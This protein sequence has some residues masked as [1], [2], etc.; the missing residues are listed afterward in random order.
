MSS[1]PE[2]VLRTRR[3]AYNGRIIV[4]EPGEQPRPEELLDLSLGGGFVKSL[5]PPTPGTLVRLGLNMRGL[6]LKTPA[7]VVWSRTRSGGPQRPT[8]MGVQFVDLSPSQKKLL[9][10]QITKSLDLGLKLKK[11]TPPSRDALAQ[12]Q[13]KSGGL[14]TL[15]SKLKKRR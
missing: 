3:V 12:K 8:G 7:R 4:Q 1:E 6:Q 5:V 15:L 11:G 10:Q 13:K 14:R 2:T 9:Y